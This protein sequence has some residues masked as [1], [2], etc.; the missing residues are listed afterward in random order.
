VRSTAEHI[1]AHQKGLMRMMVRTICLARAG[2]KI[3]PLNLAYDM[4]RFV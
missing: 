3:G 4:R 2:V 1:F